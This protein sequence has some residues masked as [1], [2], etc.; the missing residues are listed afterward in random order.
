MQGRS[1]WARAF[2]PSEKWPPCWG[3]TRAYG[4][5]LI[6]VPVDR[7]GMV[8][9]RLE[10]VLNRV[11]PKLIYTIP[12]FQNPTGVCMSMSR[13]KHLVELAN[14]YQVPVVEED[15]YGLLHFGNPPAPPLA[16]M[17]KTGT[18]IYL[19]SMSKILCSGLRLG[20]MTA[21]PD[22]V[23]LVSAAK[24][25]VDLHNNNLIQHVV[26]I[27]CRRGFLERHLRMIREK[28]MMKRDAMLDAL[29]RYAPEGMSWNRP[30]G[31]YYIWVTLP[32][33]L[34]ATRLLQEAAERK[35][36]FVVGPVFYHSA[37]GRNKMRLNFT[38]ASPDLVYRGTKILCQTVRDLH[39]KVSEL[40]SAVSQ[41]MVPIV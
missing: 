31:G 28:Y 41:E 39:A 30:E 36:F 34:S 21:P 10:S 25:L 5:K 3:L 15:P 37:E 17:D 27:Y 2:P 4:V 29:E 6:G 16:S 18:V 23:K 11:R 40:K 12:T 35:V 33:N 38:Y 13:R 19:N 22:L 32:G 9:E 8:V 24:Q 7:D 20:W 14:R 26:D 1:G